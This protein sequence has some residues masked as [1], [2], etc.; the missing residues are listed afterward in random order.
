[1]A[2]HTVR[3]H[4]RLPT[5]EHQGVALVGSLRRERSQGG[6]N[7]ESKSEC[8]ESDEQRNEL[9]KAAARAREPR[10][11]RCA[12]KNSTGRIPKGFRPPAQGCEQR[13]T[14]GPMARG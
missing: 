2:R 9:F 5:A 7:G 1:M 12:G 4:I 10:E 13:A 6:E 11:P 3:I 14:L 8:G